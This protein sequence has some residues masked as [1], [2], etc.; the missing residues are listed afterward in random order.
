MRA[1][2]VE[3]RADVHWTGDLANGSGTVSLSSSGVMKGQRV[4]WKARTGL[5]RGMTTPEEL[6][7]AAHASC[8]S[9]A[10]AG[11][12]TKAGYQAKDLDVTATVVFAQRDGVFGV[13][14]STIDVNGTIP[15]LDEPTFAKIAAE[16]DRD[17]PVSRALRGNVEIVVKTS[18][19]AEDL[20]ASA[21]P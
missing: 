7:A 4:S 9:M 15:G 3:Q 1:R 11:A 13:A 19:S 5:E 12:L 21:G 17:C 2:S 10:L 18:L 6:I 14:S 16:A 8:Y 20:A